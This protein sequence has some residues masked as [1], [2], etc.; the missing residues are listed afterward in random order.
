VIAVSQDVEPKP[1]GTD[2]SFVPNTRIGTSL[3]KQM[4]EYIGERS[5]CVHRHDNRSLTTCL[6]EIPCFLST[7]NKSFTYNYVKLEA[8]FPKVSWLSVC[9]TVHHFDT[10]QKTNS[11]AFTTQ[12][13]YTD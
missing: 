5:L 9:Y 12:A 4:A 3:L 8:Y 10:K 13:S 1:A 6:R 2:I 11:V 7:L